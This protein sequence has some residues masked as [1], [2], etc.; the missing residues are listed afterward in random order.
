LL[1][2]EFCDC[3]PGEE[4]AGKLVTRSDYMEHQRISILI[5]DDIEETRKNIRGLLSF[6]PIFNVVGEATNGDEAVKLY[7]KLT[8]DVVIMDLYMPFMSGVQATKKI[9]EQNPKATIIFFTVCSDTS[10]KL[11]AL[12]AGATEWIEKPYKPGS[13]SIDHLCEAIRMLGSKPRPDSYI[14]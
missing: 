8:P 9:K 12:R 11:L 2:L 13:N 6:E 14:H 1:D 10:D 4:L 7:S 5:V 3:N